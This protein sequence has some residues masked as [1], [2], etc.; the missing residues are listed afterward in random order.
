VKGP[1]RVPRRRDKMEKKRILIAD[2]EEIVRTLLLQALKP[3]N[4]EVD[5]VENGLEAVSH[6]DKKSYDLVITDYVMPK[7]DGLELTRRIKSKHPSTPIL[8]ITGSGPVH[9]LLKSGATAYIMKPF[10]IFELQD[11][12]ETILKEE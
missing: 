7:M 11:M 10:K 12:V 1:A 6:I 5:V 4:Y 2:D 3:H 8:V 9:D